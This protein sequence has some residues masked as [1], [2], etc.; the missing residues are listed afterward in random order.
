MAGTESTVFDE[1]LPG[2]IFRCILRRS[3]LM[4]APDR[5]GPPTFSLRDGA[6]DPS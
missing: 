1:I 5:I 6:G 4:M 2:S 3:M